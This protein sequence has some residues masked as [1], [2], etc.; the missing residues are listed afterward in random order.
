MPNVRVEFPKKAVRKDRGNSNY[1]SYRAPTPKKKQTGCCE[2]FCKIFGFGG[3]DR[4][5]NNTD[6]MPIKDVL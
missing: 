5:K 6:Y 2:A 3:D 1:N 4:P